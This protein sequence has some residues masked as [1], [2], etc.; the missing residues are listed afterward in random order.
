V[1]FPSSCSLLRSLHSCSLSHSTSTGRPEGSFAYPTSPLRTCELQWSCPRRRRFL[2]SLD[3]TLTS[4]AYP[5][6]TLMALAMTKIAIT[7][8]TTDWT[9]MVIFA[10]VRTGSVSV[11]LK[12][13]AFVKERYR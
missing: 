3:P 8:D 1:L 7:R 11:G 2:L 13:V 4:G 5:G 10:Q 12:A 6:R 9:I